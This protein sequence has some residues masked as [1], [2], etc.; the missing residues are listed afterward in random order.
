MQKVATT[1]NFLIEF[2]R[3]KGMKSNP[4]YQGLTATVDSL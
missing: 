2:Q 3:I 4:P 1:N